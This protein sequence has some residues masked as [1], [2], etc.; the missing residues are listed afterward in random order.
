M[1][2]TSKKKSQNGKFVDTELLKSEEYFTIDALSKIQILL[3]YI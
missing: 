2:V 1:Y 3:L